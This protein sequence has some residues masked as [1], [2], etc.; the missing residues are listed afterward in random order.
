MTYDFDLRGVMADI[1][2]VAVQ[3]WP[4]ADAPQARHR[5]A[6]PSCEHSPPSPPSHGEC[7]RWHPP[8]A[9]QGP[10]AAVQLRE[11]QPYSPLLGQRL[12]D[13]SGGELAWGQDGRGDWWLL[14]RDELDEIDRARRR[15][16]PWEGRGVRAL[17][18]CMR[19]Y[20]VGEGD[21]EELD[22]LASPLC[23]DAP[24]AR[25]PLR[26]GHDA[27][28]RDLAGRL[29]GMSGDRLRLVS[30]PHGNWYM[31]RSSDAD[32]FQRGHGR[33]PS[34]VPVEQAQGPNLLI[35]LLVRAQDL[36]W[37][38]RQARMR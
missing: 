36:S 27:W 17:D 24:R 32:W 9:G 19:G 3:A 34:C 38:N 7:G 31:A 29:C 25:L 18:A 33:R 8:L 1:A 14:P 21:A 22:E 12:I 23:G 6:C 4:A 11:G 15:C 26:P 16:E 37:L 13:A 5:D 35:G 30:D 2:L 28:S 10:D 20:D